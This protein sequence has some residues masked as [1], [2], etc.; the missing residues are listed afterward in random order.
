MLNKKA[1]LIFMKWKAELANMDRTWDNVEGNFELLWDHFS[2]AK[3]K[4][5]EALTYLERA[6]KAHYPKDNVIKG[7]F[8]KMKPYLKDQGLQEYGEQ[9][10]EKID[11]KCK[12]VFFAFYEIDGLT[13][14]SGGKIGG[15]SKAEY[16]KLQRYADSHPS[17]DWEALVEEKKEIVEEDDINIDIDKI[18]LDIDLGEL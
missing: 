15:M 6:S 4:M 10:K 14:T 1:D 5:D 3:I 18:D 13:K 2:T 7:T 9:W 16:V 12:E 11:A 8:K 17:V